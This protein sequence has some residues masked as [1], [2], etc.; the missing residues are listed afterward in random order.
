MIGIIWRLLGKKITA[1]DYSEGQLTCAT[2][3]RFLGITFFE[4][5]EESK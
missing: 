2:A 4:K 5:D 1:I 3:Y